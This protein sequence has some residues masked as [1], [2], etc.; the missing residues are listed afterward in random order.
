MAVITISNNKGGIAK[1]TTAIHLAAYL[2]SKGFK[3]LVIDF[4]PQMNLTIGYKIPYEYPYTSLS[5]LNG[6]PNFRVTKKA[7]N[8]YIMAGSEALDSETRD[9]HVLRTRLD[10][11]KEMA[12]SNGQKFY[13][14][15]VLDCPP[16]PLVKKFFTPPGS[17]KH[18]HIPKLN[19][20]AAA[21]ADYA[22]I[23]MDAEEFSIE[24]LK[25]FLASVIRV[26]DEFNPNLD[27]AG[28]FFSKVLKNETDFKVNY[29]SV[30]NSIPKKYFFNT[31]IR[32]DKKIELS[33]KLGKSVF[34]IAPTSRAA[35]DY[36]NLCNELLQRIA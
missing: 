14:H 8:L 2:A 20:I 18:Y 10:Q 12:K 28:V 6:E 3:L 4:D 7:D 1:T 31:Y 29:E 26:R 17:K 23:P 21:C 19:E 24:G 27:V 32:K 9:I 16:Q 36:N 33:K 15:V 5:F 22:V 30:K 25:R 35:E 13:D 11:L 34:D